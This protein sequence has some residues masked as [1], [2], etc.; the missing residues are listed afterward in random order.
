[1]LLT[2]DELDAIQSLPRDTPY[3]IRNVSHGQ[4]SI[5]RHYGGC[6]FNGAEYVYDPT[7]DTLTRNDV[8]RKLRGL[9]KKKPAQNPVQ[10]GLL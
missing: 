6:R 5:A 3:Q 9:R 10:D 1:M 4:L 2:D 8:L 7:D